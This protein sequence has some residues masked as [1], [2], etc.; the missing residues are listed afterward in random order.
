MDTVGLGVEF[1]FGTAYGHNKLPVV[2]WVA[3][4]CLGPWRSEWSHWGGC[5][6]AA[7]LLR[8]PHAA[9]QLASVVALDEDLPHQLRE[10]HV[11]RLECLHGARPCLGEH[12]LERRG[13]VD[14]LR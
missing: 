9:E 6:P 4:R 11:P 12:P 3:F 14:H 7:M 1:T 5:Q 13:Q 8:A 2:R 10:A